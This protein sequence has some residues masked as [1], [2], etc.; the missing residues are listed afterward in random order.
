MKAA[1]AIGF[2]LLAVCVA[3]FLTVADDLRHVGEIIGVGSIG[4]AGLILFVWGELALRRSRRAQTP[5]R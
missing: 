1:R 3:G 2:F 5:K 4:A